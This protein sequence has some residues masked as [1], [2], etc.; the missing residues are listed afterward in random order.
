MTDYLKENIIAVKRVYAWAAG[1]IFP[2]ISLAFWHMLAV[3]VKKIEE[4]GQE[5]NEESNKDENL[6]E[7]ENDKNENLKE[8]EII[9]EQKTENVQEQNNTEIKKEKTAPMTPIDFDLLKT[10][11]KEDNIVEKEKTPEP[12]PVALEEKDVEIKFE[13]SNIEEEK[14]VF[15]LKKK[16]EYKAEPLNTEE[17]IE[18]KNVVKDI[19]N[20]GKGYMM[21]KE[22]DNISKDE[23]ESEQ[24]KI[25]EVKEEIKINQLNKK[26]LSEENKKY[27]NEII[28]KKGRI[29]DYIEN[30]I[31][32]LK[33]DRIK[34][35]DLLY[36]LFNNGEANSGDTLPSYNEFISRI[37]KNATS[38]SY[39]K[40]FLTLCNYLDVAKMDDV[41]RK[42]LMNYKDAVERFE[43]YLNYSNS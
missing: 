21:Y 43:A 31:E 7:K 36:I 20:D 37:D 34:F 32:K 28:D 26:E 38:E 27:F 24:Q 35:P 2:I 14:T 19:I 18:E 39:A 23:I 8:K 5:K 41:N 13:P 30:K 40:H 3:F 6:K 4:E 9:Q 12:I 15:N 17:E 16:E 10:G 22:G 29:E 33:Q 25:E 11:V 1:G 42:A